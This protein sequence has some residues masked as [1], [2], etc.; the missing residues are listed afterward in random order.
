MLVHGEFSEF[1]LP[2]EDGL[3]LIGGELS[4]LIILRFQLLDLTFGRNIY[5]ILYVLYI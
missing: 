4:K 1:R 2:K 3:V 5:Y